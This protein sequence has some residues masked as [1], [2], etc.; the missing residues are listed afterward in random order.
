MFHT[1][2]VLFHEIMDHFL[3]G[4]RRSHLM[5][6]ELSPIE[7]C[8]GRQSSKSDYILKIVNFSVGSRIT[9]LAK[10]WRMCEC[11]QTG[12]YSASIGSIL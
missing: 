7:Y 9:A 8:F 5:S 4:L 1:I 6:N 11:G 2:N 10:T 3:L 12:R